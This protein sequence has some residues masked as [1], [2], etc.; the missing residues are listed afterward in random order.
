MSNNKKQALE[1]LSVINE[2]RHSVS[3]KQKK[4][5]INFFGN[6]FTNK[7]YDVIFIDCIHA[8]AYVQQDIE[9]SRKK[10]KKNGYIIF[11]DY[12]APQDVF[13][14]FPVKLLGLDENGLPIEALCPLEE[15]TH[16]A[17]FTSRGKRLNPKLRTLQDGT[18][19]AEDPNWWDGHIVKEAVDHYMEANILKKV[20]GI[21]YKKGQT[22]GGACNLC[23]QDRPMR[24]SEGLI[25]QIV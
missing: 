3:N 23:T 20:K 13:M 4:D 6:D 17:W 18:T 12:G 7:K 1:A 11:D 22:K 15:Q 24:D 5:M 2:N 25:C 10:L 9:N 19:V 21:G 8:A 16:Y 14:S